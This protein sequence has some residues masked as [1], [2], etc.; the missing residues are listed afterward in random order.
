MRDRV[1]GHR[2]VMFTVLFLP[3]V[4]HEGTGAGVPEVGH[5]CLGGRGDGKIPREASGRQSHLHAV[6]FAGDSAPSETQILP[7]CAL[8]LGRAVKFEVLPAM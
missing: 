3:G 5:T 8:T 1:E 2:S 6:S 7:F 4:P